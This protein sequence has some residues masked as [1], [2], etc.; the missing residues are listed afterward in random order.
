MRH[1]YRAALGAL[2]LV[3]LIW[4]SLIWIAPGTAHASGAA[5]QVEENL[6]AGSAI[7]D[8]VTNADLVGSLTH[9]LAGTDA[10][11][12]SIDGASGQ[13]RTAEPLDYEVRDSYEAIVRIKHDGGTTDT[14]VAI[15]VLDVE[16]PGTVSVAPATP[17][18]GTVIR[19][20]LTDPD[21]GTRPNAV[22]WRWSV[23]TD[24]VRYTPVKTGIF[25]L[26]TR[27]ASE[28]ATFTPDSRHVGKYL[29]V[30]A[31]YHDRR[32]TG[33]SWRLDK[34]AE[35]TS[36]V[37]IE[38]AT[39]L[40]ELTVRPLV[41]GLSIPWDIAFTPDGT[42]LITERSGKIYSRRPDGHM[43]R[44][45]AD[46]SDIFTTREVGLMGIAVDPSFSASNALEGGQ[47]TFGRFYTC[48]AV[49]TDTGREVQVIKWDMK[50]DYSAAD[51]V[52]E[53]LVS[54]IP[55]TDEGRHGGCR[56]RFGPDGHLW[57]T[58]GDGAIAG[59]PQDLT[60]LA[61][62]V[63]RVDVQTGAGAAGNPFTAPS[64][65]RIYTYG[66][67]NPQGLAFRPGTTEAWTV[68]HGPDRDDEINLL[69]SGGNYG[70]N[71][72]PPYNEAV[73]MT[74]RQAFPEAIEAK[75]QSWY[76]AIAPSGA[77]FLDGAGWG[78]W[79]GRL[80][81]ALLK[82]QYLKVFEF[83]SD[84]TLLSEVLVPELDQNY[85]RLRSPVLGPDGA[86]YIT[87]SNGPG[88]DHILQVFGPT[89]PRL[90][91]PDSVAYRDQG[92]NDLATFT[93]HHLTTPVT[94]TLSGQDA[95]HFSV[96]AAGV[97]S[98]AS[99]PDL[100][101]P[102]DADGDSVYRV[103]VEAQAA[104]G[105]ATA[106]LATAVTVPPPPPVV[107]IFGGVGVNE[108]G[109]TRFIITADPAPA[110][111]LDVSV[112]VSQ[113]GNYGASLGQR[114][115]TIP[116][117]GSF[118][119]KVGTT[120]DDADEPDGSVTATLD[121]PAADAGYTVSANKG[122]ATVSVADDDDPGPEVSITASNAVTEGG[123]A[124]FVI[125]ADPAPAANLVVSVTLSAS[126]DYGA[127]TGKRMVTIPS[128]GSTAKVTIPTPD[129]PRTLIVPTEGRA[130]VTV[131][132]T[133]DD[134][135]EA[136]GSITATL[137][138]PA[139]DAGYTVSAS[140]G[141]ATASVA[142]DD[143][144]PTP[145]RPR[146]SVTA[147]SGVT[148]GSDA[149]FTVTASP[150]PAAAVNVSVTLSASGDYG[151]TA[152]RRTVTIPTTGSATLTVGT[153]NDDMD[154]PDGSVTATLDSPAGDA[155]YTV[156]T[157]HGAATVKVS[158]DDLL[159]IS[160]S[161]GDGITEG[162]DASFTI[163]ANP[164][165]AA[166]LDVSITVSQSGDYGA[167]TGH[168]TVTIP[169]TGSVTLTIGT[170]ND[171]ADE[172]DG[173]VTVFVSAGRGYTPSAT[174][175][176]ARVAVADDDTTTPVVPVISISAGG[177]V[178]EGGDAVFTVTA[179]P[180]PAAALSVSVTV[181]QSGDYGAATGRQTVTIPT[182]GS[183]TL[184]V[185]TTN[186]GADEADGSVTTTL[187]T[188]AGDAGYTVSAT[189]G[190]ATVSVSDDDVP[191]ISISAGG[192]VTEG[193]DASFTIT[194]SPAPAAELSVSVTVTQS[195]DYGAATGRQTVTIPTTGSATLTIGTTNDGADEAD[196]SVTAT[197][198]ASA[199]YTVSATQGAATV[200]VSDDDVP[201]ISISAGGGVT[202]GGDASFT[203]TASPAPAAD[204][205]VSV[206]VTQSGDYGA[207]TGSQ[208]VIIPTTGSAT[209][210][211][212]TAN[213]DADEADGSVTATVNTGAGYT[214][215]ATQGAATVS[216]ADDDTTAPVVPVISVSA[217]GGV[218]EG[219]D[220]V[221]T[222]TASPVPAAALS[223][224]VT[225]TQSGDY[226]A[227]TGSQTVTIPTTGSA[228][229]TIGTTND[230]ADEADG[231]VT[232]TLN[233]GSGYTV[234]ATQGAA[235]VSVA[236]DDPAAKVT[237]IGAK[238]VTDT[239]ATIVWAP[240]GDGTQYQVGWY[241][242]P[243][244]PRLR[245]AT[246]TQ[247]EHQ[248]TGLEPES[249]YKVFV[250]SLRGTRI[251]GIYTIA[252]TTLAS[253]ES[254]DVDVGVTQ[255]PPTPQV[256]VTA[257]AA[258]T[259]GGDATFTISADPAPETDLQVSVT[260]TQSGDYGASTGQQVVTIPTTGSVTLT[261]GTAN[262]DADEADGSVTATVNTGSGYTVSASQGAATVSVADDD[263]TAP[264]VP[265]IS[266]SAGGGVTE[267]GDAVFTVTASPAPA[268]D[269]DVSVTVS[270]SG[271]YG[272]STGQQVVTIPTTGSVTLTIGTANDDADE[273]DGSV[274]A[275]LDTPAADAGYTVSATQ[276]AATVSV[277][278]DD[279]PEISISA[280]GS[281]TEGG[282]ASFTITANPTP[283]ADLSVS[284][285]VTSSGDY[286]AATGQQTVTIPTTGSATLTIGTTN[287]G[288]D[289]ADG[290]VT[291]TLVDGADYDLGSSSAATVTV[292]D[293]DVPE[294]SVSA[295]GGVTEGGDAVFTV[296]A[297]PVPAA[298]LSVSVTVAQ[299]GDYGAATGRHT[300]TIGTTG[301]AT[302]TIGTTNDGADETDGSVTATVNTATDYT[303]SA[304]QG[305][306]TVSVAD[307][308]P[309]VVPEAKLTVT[310]EDASGTEGDVVSFRI[311]L[312]K[313]L[314]EELEVNWY[315]GPAWHLRDN[316]A[317]SSDY[318]A[319]SGQMTFAP[320]TTEMTAEIWL[321]QDNHK[322]P[323]EYFAVE[324]Y[325]PGSWR[326]PD[327]TGTMTITDDD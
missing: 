29:K 205:S 15:S 17:R 87:T 196:G 26:I 166:D 312:S 226:G 59:S 77:V 140:Q 295:G 52:D 213:D 289:E 132:T 98:F 200:S 256:S 285:T 296:T 92:T 245:Y 84:G 144:P 233:T 125:L 220:A 168:R 141:A 297:S 298:D 194:A 169:T 61:G 1:R 310:V 184:T 2:P 134:V 124:K 53:P 253:G 234:S 105:G 139:S 214:V 128:V 100:E 112:T 266:I 9:S 121:A 14:R 240:Q 68:E 44:V 179:S 122:A 311:I 219:G 235:T 3:S 94:W 276:G 117:T 249:G 35:W 223:V 127:A 6:P 326:R 106:R 272:A 74:D 172:A 327:A 237:T 175:S 151:A 156:S 57:I 86:L 244:F 255:P 12:F 70:W 7:G 63:L 93:P 299:S 8:P 239:T 286:G 43:Q 306:A 251:F 111:D 162:G 60:S 64:D 5:R 221:F 303:V 71:P 277:S 115:V 250:L 135:Q 232:A 265:V 211:V 293:D 204:L 187:D 96:S 203:I 95:E 189:Q 148:E 160:V 210:T 82:E 113:S 11:S 202:E 275:T 291:A 231:S 188:P 50:D 136:D 30:N 76:P 31:K 287:D 177:G 259:E 319:M 147:G 191:E 137:D 193:G 40:P 197:V 19:A 99:P 67:R 62:K 152:G 21:G 38:A 66:H 118:T 322:E 91:G 153:A 123:D 85:G 79:N 269:L 324:A 154:E 307:D 81:V 164:A 300:V 173:L 45:E 89:T 257:G 236:D 314:T 32:S 131:G 224:S 281:V 145:S 22:I 201:E 167:A 229:L 88:K 25:G 39:A 185:G 263:T 47:A 206:T 308:D 283:A 217:G 212:G 264:V 110:A 80:A 241:Q 114:T 216:V 215:S 320:G 174:Q 227:A 116:T 51:R 46:V 246:T 75:W 16:E 18:A 90:S 192:G 126:G 323:D 176:V 325:L 248:I 73:P 161:A 318:W 42:M 130:V 279:V 282:D 102:K 274:T 58:T 180:A 195:G 48:M 182:T 321:K 158:D 171:D 107:S 290:S 230:G 37:R 183:A 254:K 83:S 33:H 55:L 258:V 23:S 149:T 20:R 72:T 278:D 209:L 138:T 170:T 108:G 313:A 294:I 155:G 317:H 129:G 163:T 208:T 228:T 65:S 165:P 54:G 97:L 198:N 199:G 101:D 309:P 316:Q 270:Q 104:S 218:T 247:T 28:V 56:I 271:D 222:V 49:N 120:N 13:L 190:A 146:V 109:E 159:E 242:S 186:D 36:A 262:D 78:A 27:S 260:V 288:A 69:T 10:D 103:L 142:D 143:D 268:A 292:S 4:V 133:N 150:A 157:T 252:V 302:L 243:G 315:A 305:A 284:V 181:S 261:V 238:Q 178:T 267:G 41:S 225:V 280:G 273:A 304:S 34:S 207:A 24:G 301:S 119:L